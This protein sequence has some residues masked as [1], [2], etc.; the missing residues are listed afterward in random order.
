MPPRC[1]I[2]ARARLA[3]ARPN[4]P[5]MAG[6]SDA[7]NSRFQT[8]RWIDRRRSAAF[9][10]EVGRSDFLTAIRPTVNR[11]LSAGAYSSEL[12]PDM[13]MRSM[14][15]VAAFTGRSAPKQEFARPSASGQGNPNLL[16]NTLTSAMSE[17]TSTPLTPK[18]GVQVW[19]A[20]A[21]T[22][23]IARIVGD[24]EAGRLTPLCPGRV[25]RGIRGRQSQLSLL[26][27]P[28]QYRGLRCGRRENKSGS[29]T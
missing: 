27:I 20:R 24:A 3:I 11:P 9:E 25:V 8:G 14:S 17:G 6:D 18:P 13:C 22:H 10:A 21:D 2:G 5:G 7:A 16:A 1:R 29:R 26:Y 23:P 12:T 19:T 28:R 15:P 4:P